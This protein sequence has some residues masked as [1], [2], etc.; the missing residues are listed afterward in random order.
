MLGSLIKGGIGLIG[1]NQAAK[2][3]EKAGGQALAM[4]KRMHQ[5]QR[6]DQQPFR[7]AG[8]SALAGMQDADFQR[9]FG[10]SDFQADPGYEFRLAQGQKALERS[11]AAS[12]ILGSGG[13]L[14]ALTDYAQ[15]VASQ[16]YGNAYDRF[17]A[18][19]DRRFGRLSG[20]A[21][22]GQNATNQMGQASANYGNNYGNIAMGLGDVRANKIGAQAGI[23]G[24]FISDVQQQAMDGMTMGM[25]GGMGGGGLGGLGKMSGPSVA[26]NFTPTPMGQ[27]SGMGN[28]WGDRS[29][30][31]LNTMR[32]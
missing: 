23:L 6:A 16:E 15:G 9:D 27:S 22:M 14:K 25:S 18:D 29:R 12:G 11:K 28:L 8:L 21:G 30:N 20:I 17:N 1:A 10:A 4:Q 13:T 24:G 26:Q 3:Q 7:Q 31:S 2:A 32:A 19:R 5:E